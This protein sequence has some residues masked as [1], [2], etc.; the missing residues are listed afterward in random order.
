MLDILT[1]AFFFFT[2]G[3]NRN[4]VDS[5]NSPAAAV[6]AVAAVVAAA[7]V[8][9]VAVVA[10]VAIV[11]EVEVAVAEQPAVASAV[12]FASAAAEQLPI[13]EHTLAED[14]LAEQHLE[15]E[16][17]EE[18]IETVNKGW[19]EVP[20]LAV[21]VADGDVV[22]VAGDDRNDDHHKLAEADTSFADTRKADEVAVVVVDTA[23]AATVVCGEDCLC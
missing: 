16:V 17:V 8:V 11:V 10:A 4:L 9:A 19:F 18:E 5:S 22:A 14:M 21:D 6:V 2:G 12:V 1:L 7:A 20:L 15:P 13:A 3:T 23:F